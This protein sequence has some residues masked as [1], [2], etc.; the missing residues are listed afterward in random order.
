MDLL[1]ESLAGGICPPWEQ[2]G[3]F[4]SNGRERRMGALVDHDIRVWLDAETYIGLIRKAEAD[5]RSVSGYVKRLIRQ[6]LAKECVTLDFPSR[7]KKGPERV[8]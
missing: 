7:S 6:E 8:D 5:E 4:V 2:A 3:F 1:H